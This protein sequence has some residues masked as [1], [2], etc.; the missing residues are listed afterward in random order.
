[1][2]KLMDTYKCNQT[3]YHGEVVRLRR[4]IEQLEA[5][6]K[7][8]IGIPEHITDDRGAICAIISDMLD[9]PDEHGIYPTTIAFNRLEELVRKAREE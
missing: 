2:Q 7:R 4:R 6:N 8:L 5:E 3:D 1:M 9:N